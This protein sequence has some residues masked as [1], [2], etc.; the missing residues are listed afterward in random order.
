LKFRVDRLT[1]NRWFA[2]L[3]ILSESTGVI[4]MWS[5]LLLSRLLRIFTNMCTRTMIILPWSLADVEIRL[6]NIWMYATL[7]AIRLYSN[8]IS[9]TC[10][11]KF[12]IWFAFRSIF[13][14][15]KK[16]P[17][18][19]MKMAKM[20]LLNMH[21]LWKPS[22]FWGNSSSNLQRCLHC[23]WPSKGWF[24]IVPIFK[25]GKAYDNRL[26]ALPSLYYHLSWLHSYRSKG[27]MEGVY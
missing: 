24:G 19:K 12:S 8:S 5:L 20:L 18:I 13:I 16:L 21:L 26:L 4:L 10:R 9:L 2:T 11:S 22:H 3:Y 27:F 25:K 1:I 23:K 7:V 14:R 15:S 17:F 6:S